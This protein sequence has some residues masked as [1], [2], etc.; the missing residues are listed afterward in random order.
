MFLNTVESNVT[1]LLYV[2]D[3]TDTLDAPKDKCMNPL[4]P[5]LIYLL[6][7]SISVTRAEW[8]F[9]RSWLQNDY[10]KGP[11]ATAEDFVNQLRDGDRF[12]I[13][14]G[15]NSARKRRE[16]IVSAAAKAGRT[17]EILA[18]KSIKRNDVAIELDVMVT[19]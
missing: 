1:S 15:R 14:S 6:S 11:F 2:Y 17:M 3:Y 9:S 10:I 19:P 8:G 5:H 13:I 18:H 4:R 16:Q 12:V 7:T